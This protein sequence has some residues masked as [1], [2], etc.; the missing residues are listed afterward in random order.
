MF[1]TDMFE[2]QRQ[3]SLNAKLPADRNITH[4]EAKLLSN[5]TNLLYKIHTDCQVDDLIEFA[6]L[7][8]KESTPIFAAYT[9]KEENEIYIEVD[10]A[11]PYPIDHFLEGTSL[12]GRKV[13]LIRASNYIIS[14]IAPWSFSAFYPGKFVKINTSTYKGK[15][16]QVVE[17]NCQNYPMIRVRFLPS[18]D[19]N[20]LSELQKI[21]QS[22]VTRE[23]RRRQ[24]DYSPP[25]AYFNK[26][27]INDIALSDVVSKKSM[28]IFNERRE[29]DYWDGMS[30]SGKFQ[31]QSIDITNLEYNVNITLQEYNLF[32]SDIILPESVF[33]DFMSNTKRQK[34]KIVSKQPQSSLKYTIQK[35]S[36]EPHSLKINPSI[37]YISTFNEPVRKTSYF[38]YKPTHTREHIAPLN[39]NDIICARGSK[40]VITRV[41]G[42]NRFTVLFL[43]NTEEVIDYEDISKNEDNVPIKYWSEVVQLKDGTMI[44]S[45]DIVRTMKKIGKVIAIINRMVLV[46][47]DSTPLHWYF[48][49]Q[50]VFHAKSTPKNYSTIESPCAYNC[51]LNT[52]MCFY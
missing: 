37:G 4:E 34:P 18:I 38:E 33:P 35:K 27:M 41:H 22:D 16:A 42:D 47:I 23:M 10:W 52:S 13:E 25:E 6:S 29:F 28:K 32:T 26:N 12:H 9:W 49:N 17:N 19:Y 2:E 24:K 50:V 36:V 46:K 45:T 3:C 20:K 15:I 5:A 51:K 48:T 1:L 39:V 43:N 40:A 7:T 30:F 21:R 8:I 14:F 31:Y 44:G 11:Y